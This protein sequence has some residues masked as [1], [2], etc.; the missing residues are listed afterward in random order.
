MYQDFKPNKGY[1]KDTTVLRQCRKMNVY[2]ELYLTYNDD[3]EQH[4]TDTIYNNNMH[5]MSPDE[6]HR[7]CL[8]L[9]R[10][11]GID[12]VRRHNT[13]PAIDAYIEKAKRLV[14]EKV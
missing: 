13:E 11:A 9:I 3:N 8:N 4:M 10:Y 6:I 2:A 7:E 5:N 14:P 12:T 1:E